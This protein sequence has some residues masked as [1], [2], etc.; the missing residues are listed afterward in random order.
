[1]VDLDPQTL[2]A[3]L[4]AFLAVPGAVGLGCAVA[5]FGP[6]VPGFAVPW[7]RLVAVTLMAAFFLV[8]F[9]PV[10][11]EN[12][13]ALLP[14]PEVAVP[15]GGELFAVHALIVLV[16][17]AWFGLG[18]AG[19][20]RGGRNFAWELGLLARR[21]WRE[22]GV[23]LVAGPLAMAAALGATILVA[24]VVVMLRG[25]EALPQD[26]SPTVLR[27]AALPVVVRLAVSVSAG[28]VE[29]IFFRGF[30]QR[31]L[32]MMPAAV[33]FVV[34]HASYQAPLS[35]VGIGALAVVFALLT[36]WRGNVWPAVVAHFFF[37]A[38]QLLVVVPIAVS[39]AP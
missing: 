11:L 38:V 26:I 23:G 15:S 20:R 31:R 21:P 34:A 37:D 10:V 36:R 2:H 24:V 9:L 32:G 17:L 13:D 6:P 16:L 27:I 35:L 8:T 22:L 18:F 4:L 33:L 7:R 29:E 3:F 28:V 30:L 39:Q 25:P 14:D 19:A 12:P 1:M 5:R